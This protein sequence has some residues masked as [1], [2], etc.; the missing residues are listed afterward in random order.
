MGYVPIKRTTIT[1][2]RSADRC[3]FLGE[4][5]EI[6]CGFDAHKSVREK[7]LDLVT[8][9][10]MKKRGWHSRSNMFEDERYESIKTTEKLLLHI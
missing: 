3:V 7:V 10:A 5:E 2:N 6:L 1:T 8:K 4:Q 9:R